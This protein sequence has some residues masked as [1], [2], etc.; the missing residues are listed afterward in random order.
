MTSSASVTLHRISHTTATREIYNSTTQL[1]CKICALV[2]TI[3]HLHAN[4]TNVF[5]TLE[6]IQKEYPPELILV[7]K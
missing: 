6:T 3:N 1:D 2:V 5:A 4:T 7:D